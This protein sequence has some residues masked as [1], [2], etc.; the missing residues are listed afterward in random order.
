MNGGIN[1]MKVQITININPIY[2][3]IVT[4]LLLNPFFTNLPITDS[5]HMLIKKPIKRGMK[6]LNNPF[7]NLI[8][9]SISNKTNKTKIIKIKNN[10]F[11]SFFITFTHIIFYYFTLFTQSIIFSFKVVYLL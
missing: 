9:P 10:M 3:Q 4:I 11:L 2:E 1:S 7:I 6:A 8:T 5:I